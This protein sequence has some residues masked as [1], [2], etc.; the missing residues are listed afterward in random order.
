[1]VIR[2]V[3][4]IYILDLSGVILH[5]YLTYIGLTTTKTVGSGG[6][7]NIYIYNIQIEKKKKSII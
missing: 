3:D 7:R 6:G 5:E 1:M 2:T 4:D